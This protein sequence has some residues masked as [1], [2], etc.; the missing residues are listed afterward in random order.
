MHSE[1]V[2]GDAKDIDINWEAGKKV[3]DYFKFIIKMDWKI[4]GMKNNTFTFLTM[5]VYLISDFYF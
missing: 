3:S 5:P 2:A 4:L 1:K